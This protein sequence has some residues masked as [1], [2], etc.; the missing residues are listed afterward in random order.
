MV[1]QTPQK[2]V[3]TAGYG[4]VFW[5]QYSKITCFYRVLIILDN[6]HSMHNIPNVCCRFSA[7]FK[8][9]PAC[10]RIFKYSSFYLPD[11]SVVKSM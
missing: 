1:V 10:F 8:N 6:I 11:V 2:T 4:G 3:N 7:R 9:I 5:W